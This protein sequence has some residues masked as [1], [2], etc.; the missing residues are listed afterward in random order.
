[1]LVEKPF[2]L[3]ADEAAAIEDAASQHGVIALEAMWT[4][5]LP[6]M[7]RIREILDQGQL[8]GVTSL[9]VDNDDLLPSD[10][11]HRTR[12]PELGG[13]ALLDLGIYALSFASDVLGTPSEVRAIAT[14]TPTGVD[15]RLAVLLGHPNGAI[16]S[17]HTQLDGRGPRTAA[18]VGTQARIEIDSI[19]YTATGF[20]VKDPD[21]VIVERFEAPV[22]GRGMQ[23]QATEMERLIR[24]GR[25]SSDIL[26]PAETVSIMR[27]LDT[28]RRDTS[29]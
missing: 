26:P 23:F 25:S 28:I 6:H 13:G 15:G 3:D 2:A 19:W 29:G 21:D 14:P 11:L 16:A 27:T 1:V 4:R 9:L 18:I 8:G 17:I 7:R 22:T 5:W 10:P 20:T 24:E 12:R